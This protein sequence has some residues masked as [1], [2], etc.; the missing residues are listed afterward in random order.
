M[1]TSSIQKNQTTQTSSSICG[2]NVER[3]SQNRTRSFKMAMKSSYQLTALPES[4]V[5]PSSAGNELV[6]KL[7]DDFLTTHCVDIWNSRYLDFNQGPMTVYLPLYGTN[8]VC[9][10][11]HEVPLESNYNPY[12]IKITTLSFYAVSASPC[13]CPVKPFRRPKVSW[14]LS[15]FFIGF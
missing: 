12:I 7:N 15:I 10:F 2:Q 5:L 8:C 1:W 9:E 13:Q 11:F 3:R 14:F 6:A 4:S